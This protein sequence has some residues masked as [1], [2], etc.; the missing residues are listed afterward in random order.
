MEDNSSNISS[1]FSAALLEFLTY[2]EFFQSIPRYLLTSVFYFLCYFVLSELLS[3][4]I[5]F[6]KLFY[7]SIQ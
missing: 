2:V 5:Q 6:T 7:V 1:T 3:I 4:V